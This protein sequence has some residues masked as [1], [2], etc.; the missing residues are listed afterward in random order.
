MGNGGIIHLTARLIVIEAVEVQ[1]A[2]LLTD[3]VTLATG[4]AVHGR[5]DPEGKITAM[6]LI[7]MFH[8]H[9]GGKR[10]YAVG[11]MLNE[12]E[13]TL[14]NSRVRL[15]ITKPPEEGHHEGKEDYFAFHSPKNT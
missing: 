1:T 2:I 6:G 5:N 15:L 7:K 8:I 12:S 9:I 10:L 14:E 11:V 13:H 4:Y 3:E